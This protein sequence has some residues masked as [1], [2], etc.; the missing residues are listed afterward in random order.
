RVVGCRLARVPREHFARVVTRKLGLEA[1]A[2]ELGAQR[3]AEVRDAREIR[4]DRIPRERLERRL[5]AEHPRRPIELR[6]RAA[7]WTEER[8]PQAERHRGAQPL[9]GEMEAIAPVAA[10][11]LV[12]AVAGERDRHVPARELADAIR[13]D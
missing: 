2:E 5:G 12:A 10:E 6:I 11:A 9:L 7:E 4:F 1:R 3:V 13:R 8:A